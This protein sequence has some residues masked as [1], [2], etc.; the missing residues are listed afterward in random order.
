MQMNI[1]TFN[2]FQPKDK[3][4][5]LPGQIHYENLCMKAVNQSIGIPFVQFFV[6]ERKVDYNET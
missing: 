5:R 3:E 1:S 6:Y 4:G 2:M